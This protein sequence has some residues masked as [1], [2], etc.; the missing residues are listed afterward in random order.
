[1][2]YIRNLGIIKELKLELSNVTVLFGPNGVGKS[3]VLRGLKILGG[4]KLHGESLVAPR[5][6]PFAYVYSPIELELRIPFPKRRC[7]ELLLSYP[8]A[9]DVAS[10]L[11][12][13]F[14]STL[15]QCDFDE[16]SISVVLVP[17][18]K[19][20][21]VRDGKIEV[22]DAILRLGSARLGDEEIKLS[23]EK[24]GALFEFFSAIISPASV[25][26]ILKRGEGFECL[27]GASLK[28]ENGKV[29]DLVTGVSVKVED[30]SEGERLLLAIARAASYV[31]GGGREPVLLELNRQ[32]LYDEAE[33][34]LLRC[35][36]ERFKEGFVVFETNDPSVAALFALLRARVYGMYKTGDGAKAVLLKGVEELGSPP[37]ELAEYLA[38]RGLSRDMLS[39]ASLKLLEIYANVT[40]S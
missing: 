1:M 17:G 4:L 40:S 36:Y 30:L 34:A 8:H 6:I 3:T 11:D 32:E 26:D 29:R 27:E 22:G 37:G 19:H 7:L 24:S 15:I 35:A 38:S 16:I 28:P 5:A 12:P 10:E 18:E 14:G 20:S 25:T 9:L 33:I 13:D 21:V 31:K 2:I 39:G 23:K